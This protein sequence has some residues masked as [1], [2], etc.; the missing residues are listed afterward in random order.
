MIPLGH[1]DGD[2]DFDELGPSAQSDFAD[3]TVSA[4]AAFGVKLTRRKP[5]GSEQMVGAVFERIARGRGYINLDDFIK[6]L[7]EELHLNLSEEEAGRLFYY[8][9]R[10]GLGQLTQKDFHLAVRDSV[11]LR[12]IVSSLVH[13]GHREAEV[14]SD[15]PWTKPSDEVH[16]HPL[17][18]AGANGYSNTQTYNKWKHGPMPGGDFDDIR[19]SVDYTFHVNYTAERAKW[20]DELVKNVALRHHPAPW[21]WLVLTCGAYGAGKGYVLR[22]LSRTGVFPLD[23]VVKIDPDH[24]KEAMPE[25]Q[26]YIKHAGKQAG[27]MCHRESGFIQELCQVVSL[28]GRQ[29]TWIDGSLRD[30]KWWKGWIE[31][32]RRNYPLYRIAIFYV[33]CSQEQVLERAEARGRITGRFIPRDQLLASIDASR[34]SVHDLGPL[35][36]FVAHIDNSSLASPVLQLFEDRSGSF[37]AISNHFKSR[38]DE[39]LRFPECLGQMRLR[40]VSNQTN[41]GNVHISWTLSDATWEQV[42]KCHQPKGERGDGGGE[43]PKKSGGKSNRVQRIKTFD[44]IPRSEFDTATQHVLEGSILLLSRCHETNLDSHSRD[45]AG[46]PSKADLFCCCYGMEI[47]E[48]DG[49]G[50]VNLV[51]VSEEQIQDLLKAGRKLVDGETLSQVNALALLVVYGGFIYFATSTKRLV[52]ANASWPNSS[53][54]KEGFSEAYNSSE[55]SHFGQGWFSLQ[56]GPPHR[57]PQTIDLSERWVSTRDRQILAQGGSLYT[58]LLPGEL[59]MCAAGAFAY[60]VDDK[61]IMFAVEAG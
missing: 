7:V 19:Q 28:R 11:F 50:K 27:G 18:Q 26:G 61:P 46:I 57:I 38:I 16:R 58:W 6:A 21:P 32:A 52:A 53:S 49:N 60:V 8:F 3:V 17:Y 9:D 20:Q 51:T 25:W 45:I 44:I 31:A 55:N 30:H 15:Y 39:T 48:R 36:D 1:D 13:P 59:P 34:Q 10:T 2:D 4:A 14:P 42:T 47:E 24:F 40:P 5:A 12:R 56:F 22:W 41:D 43:I 35:A 29:N 54:Q 23:Y 33:S 37:K